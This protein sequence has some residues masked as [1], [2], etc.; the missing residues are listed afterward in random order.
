MLFFFFFFACSC[1]FVR[2]WR[3]AQECT[4]VAREQ[5]WKDTKRYATQ[6]LM[7]RT[8]VHI[9]SIV[10]VHSGHSGNQW[11]C[12]DQKQCSYLSDST[13]TRLAQYS[14]KDKL[15]DVYIT[16]CTHHSV[17]VNTCMSHSMQ[18]IVSICIYMSSNSFFSLHWHLI[19]KFWSASR[20]HFSRAEQCDVG[21]RSRF[22]TVAAG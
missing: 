21:W 20:D 10:G 12:L 9:R 5:N 4:T 22:R 16:V 2:V 17:Y 11:H 14:V 3:Q 15:N 8:I 6:K 19:I 18:I 7:E 13:G 1:I